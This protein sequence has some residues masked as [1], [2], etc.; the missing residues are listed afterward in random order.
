MYVKLTTGQSCWKSLL[1][2]LCSCGITTGHWLATDPANSFL[3]NM[4][5]VHSSG[6]DCLKQVFF[7][8]KYWT[9]YL[10]WW[11]RHD[12]AKST[13]CYNAWCSMTL[14]RLRAGL[15]VCSLGLDLKPATGLNFSYLVAFSFPSAIFYYLFISS[16]T[17]RHF[18]F[19]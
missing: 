14:R 17:F 19:K 9:K 2:N 13:K 16:H 5:I 12:T 18:T 6:W 10:W 8:V 11:E 1:W 7:V 3:Q 15:Y 4:N